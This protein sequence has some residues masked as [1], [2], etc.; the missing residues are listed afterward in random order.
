MSARERDSA[1]I[2]VFSSMH[3]TG[4]PRGRFT[5]SR[6]IARIFSWNAGSLLW[7]HIFTRCGLISASSRIS[8]TDDSLIDRTSPFDVSAAASDLWVHTFRATPS[9]RGDWHAAATTW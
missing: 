8:P 7:H 5:Y 2:P 9:V 3:R 6:T 4:S 1:C